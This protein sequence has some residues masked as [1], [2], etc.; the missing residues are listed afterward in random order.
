MQL[1]RG[2]IGTSHLPRRAAK[3]EFLGNRPVTKILPAKAI[4]WRSHHGRPVHRSHVEKY[5]VGTAAA[6]V[7]GASARGGVRTRPRRRARATR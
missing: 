4:A 7:I 5:Y 1:G 3:V 2:L 6:Q